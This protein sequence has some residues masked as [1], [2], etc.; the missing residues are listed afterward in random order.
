M[1]SINK[2]FFTYV[3]SR[4]SLLKALLRWSDFS[5][6]PQIQS[7]RNRVIASSIEGIYTAGQ[8][9]KTAEAHIR[10][11]ERDGINTI[12]NFA[13]ESGTKQCIALIG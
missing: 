11:L 4:P 3:L 2:A 6:Y 10:E 9:L 1:D 13:M 7:L 5:A 12:I 8:E